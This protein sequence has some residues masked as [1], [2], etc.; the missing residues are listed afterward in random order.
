MRRVYF[1]HVGMLAVAFM[2]V[3]G[4]LLSAVPTASGAEAGTDAPTR[5]AVAGA[6]SVIDPAL[7]YVGT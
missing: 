7:N 4:G 6:R 3:A 5:E 2:V 1:L